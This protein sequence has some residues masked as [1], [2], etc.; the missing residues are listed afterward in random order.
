MLNGSTMRMGGQTIYYSIAYNGIVANG[1]VDVPGWIPSSRSATHTL[2]GVTFTVRVN[3]GYV[4]IKA[5]ETIACDNINT[6][7]AFGTSN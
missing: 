3:A 5:D 7:F 6:A 2:D 4:A 1:D